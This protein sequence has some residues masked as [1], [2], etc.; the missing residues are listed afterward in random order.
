MRWIVLF[1]TSILAASPLRAG[2]IEPFGGEVMTGKVEF[3]FGGLLF[4]PTQGPAVK[5]DLNNLYRAQFETPAVD[6]LVPGVMLR[7][8]TRLAAPYSALTEP[9][10]QFPKRPGL[11][12]PSAEIAWVI[13][14]RFPSALAANAIAGQT[15]ALLPG[16]DFFSGT[17]RSADADAVKVMN[18]I[19]GPRRLEVRQKQVLAAILRPAQPTA[20]L[21]EFRTTDGALFCAEN[22]TAD[23]SSVTLQNAVYNGLKLPAAEIAEIRSGSNRCRPL[24]TTPQLRAEPSAGLHPQ[25]DGILVS[26]AATVITCPVPQGFTEFVVRVAPA[27]NLA[28][29]LR[30]AFTVFVNGN[31]VAR[32]TPQAVGDP[33][34]PM[35]VAVT[36]AKTISLRVDVG[37]PPGS[38]ASGRWMQAFFLRR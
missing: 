8:G 21:F 3:D 17:I 30:V 31:P 26:D 20:A 22:F 23:R 37:G 27:E 4:R 33:A 36:G 2:S 13:Y 16:G 7:D 34:Q 28:A 5:V 32:S 29:G 18:T 24:A 38:A 25:P 11:S 19:F 14:Q 6:D 12:I 15:G 1:A 9:A 10:V 35:R